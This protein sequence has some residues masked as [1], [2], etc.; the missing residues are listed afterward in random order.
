MAQIQHHSAQR[1][2]LRQ[3]LNHTGR[4]TPSNQPSTT[5]PPRWQP[6]R[7]TSPPRPASN[8]PQES[9]QRPS[10][11]HS[12]N[13]HP[14][15]GAA[16]ARDMDSP[17][18]GTG[19]ESACHFGTL[20]NRLEF[21]AQVASSHPDGSGPQFDF[22]GIV[23]GAMFSAF[24]EEPLGATPKDTLHIVCQA[25]RNDH[26]EGPPDEGGVGSG[27]GRGWCA[28]SRYPPL[29]SPKENPPSGVALV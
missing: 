13:H 7:T 15:G 12:C 21:F 26:Q 3:P 11:S 27:G 28:R 22:W 4:T 6:S 19:K 9:P 25:S 17:R 10:A 24:F 8:N 2:F 29:R 18:G 16:Q 14:E 23:D 20:K 1:I 5:A